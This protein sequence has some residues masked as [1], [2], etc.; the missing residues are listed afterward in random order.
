MFGSKK[1]NKPETPEEQIDAL[2]TFVH[3]HLWTKVTFLDWKMNFMVAIVL[4][5]LAVALIK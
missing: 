2:W 1:L 5:L 3:N 4:A